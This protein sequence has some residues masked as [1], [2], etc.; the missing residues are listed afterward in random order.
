ML[1][2]HEPRESIRDFPGARRLPGARVLMYAGMHPAPSFRSVLIQ[3][4]DM[5]ITVKPAAAAVLVF[6]AFLKKDHERRARV[7]K[8][9]GVKAE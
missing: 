2:C 1:R 5:K 4:N 9:S 6:A 7:I 3:G 8:A